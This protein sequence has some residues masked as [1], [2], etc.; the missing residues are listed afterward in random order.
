M[1]ANHAVFIIC[2]ALENDVTKRFCQKNTYS[3]PLTKV[4]M[5]G[6]LAYL[7]FLLHTQKQTRGV[8]VTVLSVYGRAYSRVYFMVYQA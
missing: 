5:V 3:R 6:I 7:Y 1:D 8:P 4:Y 2:F